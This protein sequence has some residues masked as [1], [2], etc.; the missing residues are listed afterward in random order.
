MYVFL[1]NPAARSGRGESA[2]KLSGLLWKKRV[3]LIRFSSPKEQ[4]I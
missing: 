3:F 4:A 2:G 1:V